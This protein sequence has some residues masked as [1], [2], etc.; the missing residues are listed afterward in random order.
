MNKCPGAVFGTTPPAYGTTS[1]DSST[2]KSLDTS[3]L[4][5]V[6]VADELVG[7]DFDQCVDCEKSVHRELHLEIGPHF[8]NPFHLGVRHSCPLDCH[9]KTAGRSHAAR[10]VLNGRRL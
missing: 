6:F 4:R 9:N 5:N 1:Y 2:E 10:N 8:T 3:N 7:I